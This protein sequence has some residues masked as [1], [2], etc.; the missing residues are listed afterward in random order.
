MTAKTTT[1]QQHPGKAT[2]RTAVQGFLGT[3]LTLGVVAPI[4]ASIIGESLGGYLPESAT[5]WIIAAAALVAAVSA[6][7][8]RL[9]AIPQVDAWLKRLGLAS[10]PDA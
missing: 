8:A 7:V 10:G 3:L 9:M 2:I 5:A 4:A 6:T 1:Q